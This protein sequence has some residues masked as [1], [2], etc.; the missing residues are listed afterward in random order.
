MAY[1]RCVAAFL[2]WRSH[3]TQTLSFDSTEIGSE[4]GIDHSTDSRLGCDMTGSAKSRDFKHVRSARW[5]AVKCRVVFKA[6]G[7]LPVL[8]TMACLWSAVRCRVAQF[9]GSRALK[10]WTLKPC[11]G[12]P[13][14]FVQGDTRVVWWVFTSEL[15]S[16]ATGCNWWE[17]WAKTC[18]GKNDHDSWSWL[19]L[20]MRSC[21]IHYQ[22]CPFLMADH[23]RQIDHAPHSRLWQSV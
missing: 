3:F 10:M 9:R 22:L 1:Q 19:H 17:I 8:P 4:C 7:I 12:L 5:N 15:D 6:G 18:K 23:R 2:D 13:C 21:K 20:K 16:I 14:L 11:A